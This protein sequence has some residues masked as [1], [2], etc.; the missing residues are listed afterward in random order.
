MIAVFV[1]ADPAARD[2]EFFRQR[3]ALMAL[4]A[5]LGTDGGLDCF[6]GAIEWLKDLVNPVTVSTDRRARYSTRECLP[7][8]AL[9]E[10]ARFGRVTFAA[11]ARNV[12]ARNGRLLIR[13]RLDVVR[14]VTVSADCCAHVAARDS[15]GMHAFT[16]GEHRLI[17]D[18]AALHD[19]LVAM[20]AS[21]RFRDVG[22]IGGGLRIARRQDRSHV[23]IPGVAIETGGCLRPVLLSLCVKAVVVAPMRLSVNQ[24]SGQV[25]Q[26]LT[27]AVTTLT[28]KFR[29]RRG[30]T[31]VGPPDDGALV[32]L[33]RARR[34]LGLIV[35]CLRRSE[36]NNRHGSGQKNYEQ[37]NE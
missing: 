36:E 17:A 14:I 24:R 30:K 16:I 4:R 18:A 12:H 26:L 34:I 2:A 6:L 21:A 28:L 23:T 31:G 37:S 5:T 3:H 13:S 27:G 25:R 33:Y 10:F 22:A 32:R 1:A 8:N 19:R 35:L 9:H 20:T 15:F 11:G 7:V 29:G